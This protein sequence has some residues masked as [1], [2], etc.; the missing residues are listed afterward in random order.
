M[1]D[2]PKKIQ[3]KAKRDTAQAS[4]TLRPAGL[5]A[6]EVMLFQ[7]LVDSIA[8]RR[9][10]PGAKLLEDELAATFEVSRERVRRILLVASQYRIVKLEPNKG[11]SVARPSQKDRKEAFALRMLLEQQVVRLLA[12]VPVA[13]QRVIV[14]E[15]REHIDEE[16]AALANGDRK[17][18]IRLSGEFHLKMALQTGN[19]LLTQMLQEAVTF[20]SL[21]LAAHAYHQNLDCSIGEHTQLLDA[22]AAGDVQRADGLLVDHLGHLEDDMAYNISVAQDD[23]KTLDI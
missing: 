18:Q 3:A 12:S 11:A 4:L 8:E 15:L 1:T 13:R 22:I 6:S 9:L 20:L 14:G 19:S 21:A 23:E 5:N 10:A 16:R 7:R 2:S 17:L